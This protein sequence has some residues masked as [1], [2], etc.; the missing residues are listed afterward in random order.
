MSIELKECKELDIFGRTVT[1]LLKNSTKFALLY[2]FCRKSRLRDHTFKL[3]HYALSHSSYNF[4]AIVLERDFPED[5]YQQRGSSPTS[6][7]GDNGGN[8]YSFLIMFFP[9]GMLVILLVLI[10]LCTRS[11]VCLLKS[12]VK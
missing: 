4:E 3:F 1:K 5:I 6:T 7:A 8:Q 2:V 12:W 9:I 11:N 10:F